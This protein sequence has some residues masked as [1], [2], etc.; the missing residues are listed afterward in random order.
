MNRAALSKKPA[1]PDS[2][3]IDSKGLQQHIQLCALADEKGHRKTIQGTK[4]SNIRQ[5]D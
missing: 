2:I 1:Q 5:R 3:Y 4:T